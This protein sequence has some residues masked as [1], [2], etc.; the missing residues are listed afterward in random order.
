MGEIA[1][2]MQQIEIECEAMK[3]AMTGFRRVASHDIINRQYEQLGEHYESLG[4]LIGEKQAIEVL[5]ATLDVALDKEGLKLNA[6]LMDHPFS[7]VL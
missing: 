5:I 7:Q 1:R 4:K 2:L 3:L 6:S